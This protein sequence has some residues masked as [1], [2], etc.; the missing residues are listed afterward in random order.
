MKSSSIEESRQLALEAAEQLIA[1]NGWAALTAAGIA[2]ASGMSR[3]WLHALFGGQKGL[4]DALINSLV[5]RWRSSQ[6]E[7]IAARL[8]LAET[9]E[10]SLVLLFESSPVLWTIFR[11][12]MVERNTEFENIRVDIEHLWAPVWQA[13]RRAPAEEDNAVSAIFIASALE[14]ATLVNN[15]EVSSTAAKHILV[16][17]MKGCVQPK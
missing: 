9:I 7:I 14:L 5:G 4:L 17:A 8:S 6:I 16:M 1:E 13:E 12:L 15:A 3:Q 11:Q 10:K 2:G